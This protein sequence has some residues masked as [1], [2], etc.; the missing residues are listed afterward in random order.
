MTHGERTESKADGGLAG[1]RRQARRGR[2]GA[3]PINHGDPHFPPSLARSPGGPDAA[4][5]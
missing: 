1:W 2:I 4:P 5:S 3:A